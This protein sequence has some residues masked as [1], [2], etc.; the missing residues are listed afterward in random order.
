MRERSVLGGRPRMSAAFPGPAS[1]H[2][3]RSSTRSRCARSTSS[4]RSEPLPLARRTAE[5][6]VEL[7]RGPGRQ[8][9]RALDHVREL[10]H[11]A[12]RRVA[13][14]P[15][16]RILR[17][18]LDPPPELALPALDQLPDQDADVLAPIAK[19]GQGVL[20]GALAAGLI[21]AATRPKPPPLFGPAGNGLVVMSR[22]GDIFT[23]D[24]GTG[25]ATAIVTGPEIDSDPL[26]VTGRTTL[27][28]RRASAEQPDADFLMVARAN[29]SGLKQL[30]PEPMTG[31]DSREGVVVLGAEA[32]LRAVARRTQCR[33]DLDCQR[34][35]GAFCRQ[36]GWTSD[37]EARHRRHADELRLRSG[38]SAAPGRRCAGVRWVVLGSV[39]HR[40]GRDEPANHHRARP[41][42][43]RSTAGSPSARRQQDRLRSVRTRFPRGRPARGEAARKDLRIHILAA[44]LSS[45][46]PIGEED[47]PCG[48]TQGMVA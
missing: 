39:P 37:H 43:S 5:R 3:Q 29:G 25:A 20:I 32:P 35:P 15:L 2:W 47:G 27:L 8:D 13:L 24:T 40:P 48:G 45:D 6:R 23:V 21:L 9:Q 44:D 12:R 41:W 33:D 46:V 26:L 7:Q 10:A 19:R 1:R 36:H 42:T 17:Y 16:H 28:F 30:T 22:D 14:Q 4:A 18:A 31:L 38:R 11:V 34:N